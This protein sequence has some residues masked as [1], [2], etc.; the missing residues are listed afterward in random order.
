MAQFDQQTL[1]KLHDLKEVT[2]RTTKHPAS[3]VIMWVVVSDADVFVRSVRGTKDDG[4]RIWPMAALP[5]WSSM[6]SS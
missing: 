3:A 1:R 5:H 6:A 4:T 2:V